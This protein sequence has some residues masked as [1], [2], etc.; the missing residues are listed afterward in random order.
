[1]SSNSS[2]SQ[3][4]TTAR[5]RPPP[6]GALTVQRPSSGGTSPRHRPSPL[7]SGAVT[8]DTATFAN[9]K[10]GSGP[11]TP[12]STTPIP[13]VANRVNPPTRGATKARDLLRQ[14]YGLG[15]GP[16]VPA[17]GRSTDPMD[18]G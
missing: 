12:G 13:D 17:P 3:T 18:V 8:P 5:M 7:S 14:H 15:V 2:P 4:P 11:P 16:P 6:S 10:R 1:M 9:A